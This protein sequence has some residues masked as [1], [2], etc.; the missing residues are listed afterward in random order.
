MLQKSPQLNT[1]I[2]CFNSLDLEDQI[3]Y[4]SGAKAAI[5]IIDRLEPRLYN[6]TGKL[7]VGLQS[8]RQGQSGDVRDVLCI[9]GPEWQIGLSCKHN[10]DAVKHSRLSPTINVGKEWFNKNSSQTYFDEVR[11]VFIQLRDIGQFSV[12]KELTTGPALW[13]D[14]PDK[15]ERFYVP[16]LQA[17]KKELKWL[18]KQYPGEIPEQLIRYLIGRN[19]FYKVIMN[20]KRRFTQIEAF[21]INGSLN[22]PLGKKKALVDVPLLKMP[23]KFYEIEFEDGKKNTIIV[24]CDHG[25]QVS[26]RIHNASSRVEPSLKFDVK[27]LAKPSSLLTQIEPWD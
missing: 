1:A 20:D 8:D 9:R 26:M 18:D 23:T 14:V 6:D 7:I 15:E 19:D 12:A 3:N 16:I 4:E 22:K 5:K 11:A 21:N 17:F 2:K 13:S 27:L 10:H 25:W 24:V